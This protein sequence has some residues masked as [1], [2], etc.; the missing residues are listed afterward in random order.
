MLPAL[1][2]EN[3]K[4]HLLYNFF[5]ITLYLWAITIPFDIRDLEQDKKKSVETLAAKLSPTK[6]KIISISALL[7]CS[8]LSLIG[9]YLDFLNTTLSYSLGIS[10][11]LS[12]YIVYKV[13]QNQPIWRYDAFIDGTM[14]IAP[15]IYFIL[16]M[17]YC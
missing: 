6:V 3:F 12:I 9:A 11:I 16:R 17:L 7:L 10:Y 13:D 8:V 4:W 2:I 5:F 1:L 15:S 14:L